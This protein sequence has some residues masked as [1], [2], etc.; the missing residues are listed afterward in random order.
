MPSTDADTAVRCL[1]NAAGMTT[2]PEEKIQLYVR[3]YPQ[4]RASADRL[5]AIPEIRY[6]LPSPVF[7]PRT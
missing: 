6:E 1:L 2:L 7:N 5:F 4:L 3:V